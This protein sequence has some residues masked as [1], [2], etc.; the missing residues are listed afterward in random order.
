M[1]G[2]A[3]IKVCVVFTGTIHPEPIAQLM[4]LISQWVTEGA[5]E[6]Y[7]AFSTAGGSVELGLV[8]YRYLRSLPVK[9]TTHNINRVDSI[10][11]A[12]FLG[13]DT[14]YVSPGAS[15]LFHGVTHDPPQGSSL[16]VESLQR[17]QKAVDGDH[18][19]IGEI[20]ADRTDLSRE[21]TAT[22]FSGEQRMS[23]E[24]AVQRGIATEAREF[25]CPP[26]FRLVSLVFSG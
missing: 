15:F 25:A 19:R 20:L 16:G 4:G 10:G 14:R 5:E 22:L 23:A 9:L 1:N 3:P 17:I 13:A 7:L 11:N 18:A 6:I 24:D 12:V 2:P 26:G 21:E 8:L